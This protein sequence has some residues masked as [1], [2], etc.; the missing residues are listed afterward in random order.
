MTKELAR[1]LI[2]AGAT[3]VGLTATI[4]IAEDILNTK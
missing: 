2:A 1:D 4:D 3:R